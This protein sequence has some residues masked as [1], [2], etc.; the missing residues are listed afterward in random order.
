LS[1]DKQYDHIKLAVLEVVGKHFRPEFINRI[2]EMVVFHP[3]AEEQIRGIAEIQLE[4]LR[5]RLA[6]RD[7]KLEMSEAA[8]EQLVV[9]GY[10][11]VYGARPLKRAIQTGLENPLA[12]KILSAE[13]IAG[14]TIVADVDHGNL[15]FHKK[16]LH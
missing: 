2:D 14:D 7:L 10:D 16:R 9:A 15:V 6:E 3:L 12:H 1:E 5:G 13:F 8:M 11:P 4:R